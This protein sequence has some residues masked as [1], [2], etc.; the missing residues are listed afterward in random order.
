VTHLNCYSFTA[1]YSGLL[2]IVV[3]RKVTQDGSQHS[4]S[5]LSDDDENEPPKF[6]VRLIIPADAF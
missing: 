3:T 5:D 2:N 1:F 4:A 6:R